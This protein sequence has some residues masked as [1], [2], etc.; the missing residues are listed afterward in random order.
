MDAKAIL[1]QI[2]NSAKHLSAQGR[3]LAEEKLGVPESGG[4]RDAM[5]SGMGKGALAAGALALLLGTGAGRRITGSAIKLGGLAAV[6]TVA[7]KA[8]Q[9]WQRQQT[10]DVADIGAPIGELT[11][12]LAQTRSEILLEAMIAAAKAD[13]HIDANERANIERQ[14]E[15]FGLEK[16]SRKFLQTQ[17]AQPI[18]I[19]LL[20]AKADSPEAAAEM[21]LVSRLIIDLDN[22]SEKRHLQ[23]LATA[24]GLAPGLV[25]ELER[26]VL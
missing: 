10:Q 1:E 3:D 11:H 26:Q 17:L 12:P 22:A 4:E 8:Y 23:N 6:G 20:A 24:L 15:Q 19:D 9:N 18:D 21:Y 13:G 7:Y 2:L 14:I 16:D 5:L 25:A